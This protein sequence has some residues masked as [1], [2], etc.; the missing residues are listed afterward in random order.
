MRLR[1][2]PRAQPEGTP[3]T[4]CWYF[5]YSPTLSRYRHYP[6]YESDE[7]VAIAIAIAMFRA[8]AMS[9]PRAKKEKKNKIFL[10]MVE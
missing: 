1:E 10:G 9:K 5:L 7:A 3:R 2:F 4:E 6:I 8:I